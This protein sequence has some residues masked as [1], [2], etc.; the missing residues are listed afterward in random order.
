VVGAAD[1][2]GA[3]SGAGGAGGSRVAKTSTS[4][5]SRRLCGHTNDGRE[6]YTGKHER[7]EERKRKEGKLVEH[8]PPFYQPC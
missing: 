1:R 3:A 4:N 2:H 6:E 7:R 5:R 8:G